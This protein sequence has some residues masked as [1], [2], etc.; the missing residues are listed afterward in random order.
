[1]D[2]DLH[3]TTFSDYGSFFPIFNALTW[4]R[5]WVG[6]AALNRI[7]RGKY[8][9]CWN[10]RR[11]LRAPDDGISAAFVPQLAGSCWGQHWARDFAHSTLWR[12][13]HGHE[14]WTRY[15]RIESHA[16][17][18]GTLVAQDASVSSRCAQASSGWLDERCTSCWPVIPLQCWSSTDGCSCWPCN[19]VHTTLVHTC[20]PCW[21]YCTDQAV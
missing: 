13:G 16:I 4:S 17:A 19:F 7:F 18:S 9:Q 2:D 14:H 20:F 5:L 12:N 3:P 8:D 10:W 11:W 15:M 21:L 1:M 6:M